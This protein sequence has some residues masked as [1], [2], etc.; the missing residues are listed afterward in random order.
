MNMFDD[1]PPKI[2]HPLLQQDVA[3]LPQLLRI[4]LHLMGDLQDPIDGAT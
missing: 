4:H 2:H 1:F 3:S